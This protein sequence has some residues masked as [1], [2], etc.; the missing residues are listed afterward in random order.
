MVLFSVGSV[1]SSTEAPS[2]LSFQKLFLFSGALGPK[3][4]P[5]SAM[6]LNGTKHGLQRNEN[7]FQLNKNELQ[8]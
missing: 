4:D 2:D 3:L 5:S 1:E 7:G 6:D 8:K